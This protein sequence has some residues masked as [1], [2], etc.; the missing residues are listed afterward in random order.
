MM[1]EYWDKIRKPPTIEKYYSPNN[2]F[3]WIWIPKNGTNTISHALCKHLKWHKN[4]EIVHGTK[5]FGMIRDPIER[6]AS[7][8]A[9]LT[10]RSQLE[11]FGKLIE[12]GNIQW[13]IDRKWHDIHTAPQPAADVRATP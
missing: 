6:W 5:F 8:T 4:R 13:L 12:D 3:G 10:R 2:I 1:E 9:V 7:G 11:W